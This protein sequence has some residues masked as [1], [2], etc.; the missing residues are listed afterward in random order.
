MTAF[1]LHKGDCAPC[2]AARRVVD[3]LASRW[4]PLD[5]WGEFEATEGP[6]TLRD[7]LLAV[8]AET[9]HHLLPGGGGRG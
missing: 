4:D 2:D 9:L 1:T 6:G 7:E 5:N 3:A 8:A